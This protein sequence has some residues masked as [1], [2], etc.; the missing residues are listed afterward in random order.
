MQKDPYKYFRIEAKEL[1]EQLDRGVLDLE[2]PATAKDAVGRL[3]RLAHTLKGASRVVRQAKIGE[4]SH[5]FEDALAPH[6]DGAHAPPPEV[7]NKLLAM[8]DQIKALIAALDAP[9][10]APVPVAAAPALAPVPAPAPVAVKPAALDQQALAELAAAPVAAKAAAPAAPVH[11]ERIESLRVEIAEVDALLE[12]ISELGIRMGA[13][14][15]HL[16]QS[17]RVERAAGALVEQLHKRGDRGAQANARARVLAEEVRFSVSGMRQGLTQALERAEEEL[18]QV[19]ERSEAI[20]LVPANIAFAALERGVRDAAQAVDKPVEWV[21]SGGETRLDGHVLSGLREALLHV[22]TNAVTHGVESAAERKAAGKPPFAQ[23]RLAAQRRGSRVVFSCSDD[24][25]GVDIEAVRRLAVKR[26][27]VQEAE[28]AALTPEQVI[29]FIF[30][31]GLSTATQVTELAGRG[32]GMDVVREVTERLKGEVTARSVPGKGTTV[33]I[34]VPLS[35]TSLTVLVVE[36]GEVTLAVPMDALRRTRRVPAAEIHQS[37]H[38]DSLIDEDRAIPF[39]PLSRILRGDEHAQQPRAAWSVLILRSGQDALAVGVDKIRE[40]ESVV[41]R[42][43]PALAGPLPVFAGAS[44]DS[45]GN[46]QPVVDPGGLI[47]AARELSGA[48]VQAKSSA[49]RP[50]VLVI[51]DSLT[52]RMMEKSILESAGYEVDLAVSAEDGL[53]KAAK[54]SYGLFVCDVDMPGMSGFDFVAKTR[55]D[56][57]FK[58]IPAILVTSR[59]S[60][61]DRRRGASAGASAFIVKGEFDQGVLLGKIRELIG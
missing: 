30:A 10:A 33:E 58:K 42:R 13:F 61:E 40:I 59:S 34:S 15:R 51:D 23:V 25:R 53:A 43:L 46:P 16:E 8:L 35:L 28:A 29:R 5:T 39:V 2:K 20:R 4:L 38:G 31:P 9:A 48:V 21:T 1:L 50:P 14:R 60:D 41:L 19:V 24:G 57:V 54:R 37:E 6:R 44:F 7:V 3:L 18:T 52:T 26:G 45:E 27:L 22:V 32:V 55:A 36:A 17:S 56:A 11:E 47:K 12:S 49:A